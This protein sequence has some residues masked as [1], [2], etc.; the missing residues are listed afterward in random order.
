MLAY[1]KKA[2]HNETY[3][4]DYHGQRGPLNVAEVQ[5]PSAMNRLF[6]EAARECGLPLTPDYNGAEQHGAFMYQVTQKNGERCSAAKAYLTPKLSRPNLTVVTGALTQ[7]LLFEGRRVVG[8]QFRVDGSDMRLDARREVVVSA[9]AFGSP[10]LL[11]LSGIGPA[12]HLQSKGIAP[13][14][15]L[16]G[17]GENPLAV[18]GGRFAS[19]PAGR[20]ARG[21]SGRAAVAPGRA[22]R[23]R[24][25]LR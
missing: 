2:E 23:A 6:L 1:F 7:R 12:A 20:A 15:D 8:V 24:G 22:G 16:P 5:Q 4:D 3:R 18:R 11:Q 25:C 14:V 13:I 17:V 19:G 9:G 21:R 10:Q